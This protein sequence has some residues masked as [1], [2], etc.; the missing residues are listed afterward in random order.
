M[1]ETKLAK[2][3][4]ITRG[5]KVKEETNYGI[6]YYEINMKDFD[7]NSLN[8]PT[9]LKHNG[10]D[11]QIKLKRLEKGDIVI[12]VRGSSI[13]NKIAI[14]E[15]ESEIPCIVNHQYWII[16]PDKNVLN[17]YYLLFFLLNKDTKKLLNSDERNMSDTN[18]KSISKEPLK[19]LIIELPPLDIQDDAK[20]IFLQY[21][22]LHKHINYCISLHQKLGDV[23]YSNDSNN[24]DSLLRRI[25]DAINDFNSVVSIS[26]DSL[27]SE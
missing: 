21:Q 20:K 15:L 22:E 17:S 8:M 13:T 9:E 18:M 4:F 11:D 25:E 3:S 26:V 5:V 23:I 14:F 10:S 7:G 24:L 16:R 2:C 1:Y 27:L 19:D 6:D 12:P